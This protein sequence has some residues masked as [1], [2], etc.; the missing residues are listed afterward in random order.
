MIRQ[1]IPEER[2]LLPRAKVLHALHGQTQERVFPRH[3][4]GA[5][6]HDIHSIST[7][8]RRNRHDKRVFCS[9]VLERAFRHILL[10]H[11]QYH[12]TSSPPIVLHSLPENLF[13]SW[14]C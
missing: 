14:S 3:S 12:N 1:I 6:G 4:I 2:S 8:R 10:C 5:L 7:Q 13:Y 9:L 11:I